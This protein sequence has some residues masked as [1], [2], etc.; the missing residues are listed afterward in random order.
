MLPDEK[1]ILYIQ[2]SRL[3]GGDVLLVDV[4]TPEAFAAAHLPGSVNHCVYEVA[5]ME[6]F[7][8]ACPDR[9]THIVVYGDGDPYKADMAAVGRLR[10][11]GYTAVSVLAGGL[12]KW[13]SEQRPIEGAGEMPAAMPAGRY[14]LDTERS[15]VRWVGRNLTNQHDGIVATQSGFMEINPLGRPVAG[16]VVVDLSRMQCRDI[17]D[18]SLAAMLIGHLQHADFFEVGR[19]PT[20]SFALKE[21]RP[22]EGA[23]YGQPNY[24]VEGVLSARGRSLPLS[25]NALVEPITGG[26]VFQ[27]NFD[28]NRV[29]L[30]ACYGS[31]KLF[32]RLGMHLVNDLVSID[33]AAVFTA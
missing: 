1:S 21:S 31:G 13:I 28:F 3:T 29:A 26:W 4:R 12:K 23:T 17:S 7:P 33:V 19:Y 27:A 8:K 16:E 15:K 5:F 11:L 10:A 6:A 25:L 20:A 18:T 2:S 30:G 14:K 22:V 9:A 24:V 32:E